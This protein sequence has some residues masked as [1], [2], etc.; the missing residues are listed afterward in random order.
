MNF[1][2]ALRAIPLTVLAIACEP[3]PTARGH[4]AGER[5][6]TYPSARDRATR[7]E[8]TWLPLVGLAATV[9]LGLLRLARSSGESSDAT[10][11]GPGQRAPRPVRTHRPA[12]GRDGR[13]HRP[14]AR[15]CPRT[16]ASGPRAADPADVTDA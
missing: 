15:R 14:T 1:R 3:S 16:V 12:G 2:C 7:P 6:L 11:E 13:T 5:T 4:G 10:V 8:L 9:T